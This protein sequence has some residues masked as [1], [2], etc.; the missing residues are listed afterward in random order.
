MVT[1]KLSCSCI[2]RHWQSFIS[3]LH[4]DAF[5]QKPYIAARCVKQ[6]RSRGGVQFPTGGNGVNSSARERSTR[7]IGRGQQIW[8]NSRADG[9]SPD[10]RERVSRLRRRFPAPGL[11]LPVRPDSPWSRK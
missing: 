11:A 1:S 7:V 3:D 9:D 6:R 4:F 5:G 8:C 10:K 2:G